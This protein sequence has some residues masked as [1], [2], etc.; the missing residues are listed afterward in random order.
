[1]QN[2]HIVPLAPSPFIEWL[3]KHGLM[4]LRARWIATSDPALGGPVFRRIE[5]TLL[6]VRPKRRALEMMT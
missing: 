6:V 2:M 4:D 1:M 5:P 3:H